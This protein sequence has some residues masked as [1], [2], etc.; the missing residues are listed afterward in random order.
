MLSLENHRRISVK[1]PILPKKL[2][3][4]L[5]SSQDSDVA[6][7]RW[8]C[9]DMMVFSLLGACGPPNAVVVRYLHLLFAFLLACDSV[10]TFVHHN[11]DCCAK[12]SVVSQR[13]FL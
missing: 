6:S 13:E 2:S 7:W 8:T 5:V 1:M 4:S 3:K 10:I 9:L 11:T 12:S